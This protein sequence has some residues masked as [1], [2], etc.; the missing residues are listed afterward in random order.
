MSEYGAV[1]KAE[2]VSD[3]AKLVNEE[4]VQMVTVEAPLDLPEGYT[5]YSSF[6]N[7]T[8]SVTV[9]EGGVKKGDSLSVPHQEVDTTDVVVSRWRDDLFACCVHGICHPS[10]L[11]C[12]FCNTCLLGQVMTRLKLNWCGSPVSSD[13]WKNTY[14]IM[15]IIFIFCYGVNMFTSPPVDLDAPDA[16]T[17][18]EDPVNSML[19]VV[20]SIVGLFLLFTIYKVRKHVRAKYEIPEQTCLGCEDVCCTLWCGACVTAQMARHTAN[21]HKVKAQFFSGTGIEE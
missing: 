2:L 13:A 11:N 6:H 9:P 7:R 5:F 16:P 21:Y 17:V 10:F 20:L 1:L 4:G 18:D 3:D 19:S 8:I 14:S 15:V 12:L